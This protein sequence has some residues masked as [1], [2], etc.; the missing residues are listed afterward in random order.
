M[1]ARPDSHG[2]GRGGW[3]LVLME[4]RGISFLCNST[5]MLLLMRCR[6][7]GETSAHVTGSGV[8]S[9]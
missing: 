9:M 1:R 6:C 7:Q 4:V 2:A 5:R 8:M 3:G